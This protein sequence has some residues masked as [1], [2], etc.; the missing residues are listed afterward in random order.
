MEF[1][2]SLDWCGNSSCMHWEL[3][4]YIHL[5]ND[6]GWGLFF[7]ADMNGLVQIKQLVALLYSLHCSWVRRF[8]GIL[9]VRCCLHMIAAAKTWS[10]NFSAGHPLYW[11]GVLQSIVHH[12]ISHRCTFHMVR[13]VGI[14]WWRILVTMVHTSLVYLERSRNPRRRQKVNA[15]GI[16]FL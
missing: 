9:L 1:S 5:S 2:L 15:V 7:S 14:G 11:L 13:V 3:D 12:Y 4:L 10:K 16:L 8:I 6:R